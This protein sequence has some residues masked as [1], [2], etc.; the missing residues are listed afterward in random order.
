M[1]AISGGAFHDS[2]E[3]YPPPKCHP[4][5]RKAVLGRIEDWAHTSDPGNDVL[6]LYGPAG[7]GKS[8]IAQTFADRC[9][10]AKTLVAS[11]FFSRGKPGRDTADLLWATVALQIAK[12]IPQLRKKIGNAVLENPDVFLKS[13]DTQIR[14]LIRDPFTLVLDLPL[15]S[16]SVVIID[17]LDE[18]NDDGA[19]RN[20]L[21]SI[22][23]IINLHH[24]PLRFLLASRPE[25]HIHAC[26]NSPSLR[27]ICYRIFLDESF[28][29]IHDIHIL[30]RRAFNRI[31]EKHSHTMGSVIRPW[32]TDNIIQLLAT[33]SGGIFIYAS[34]VLKFVD[35]ED[36]RPTDQLEIALNVSHS[37][38]FT[39]LDQLYRQIL[40]TCKNIPLLLRILGCI[41]FTIR[42]L[43]VPE[44]EFLLSLRAGDLHLALRRMHS[45]LLIPQVPHQHV[46]VHHAS[47]QDF[48]LSAERA[49]EYHV[50][51]SWCQRVMAQCCLHFA[52]QHRD[53]KIESEKF[54]VL[55]SL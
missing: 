37:T 49:G 11:F 44:I 33:R 31:Y 27:H 29:P 1:N 55:F 20:V 16:P 10:E 41:F 39:E 19:Q 22:A 43:S 9:A 42:P 47:L 54:V 28:Q 38:A 13:F 48:I 17:G 2:L 25:P 15:D 12:N 4:E 18:C 26:F 35:D 36:C 50:S 6:W 52:K 3:R 7:A 34:T 46:R 32:P 23:N 21:H 8:A 53:L 40:S 30:L 51:A 45:I 5:T 14:I 24:I